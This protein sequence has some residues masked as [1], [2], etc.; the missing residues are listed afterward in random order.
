VGFILE[1]AGIGV[2]DMDYTNGKLQWSAALEAQYGLK[3]GT[4]EGTFRSFLDRV[5]PDDREATLATIEKTL[6]IGG[7]F[8]LTHRAVW[9]DGTV[10]WLSGPGCIH[11]GDD[12]K[13]VRA[14]GISQDVT[15]KRALEAQY[16]Q[17]QKME[18]VG[19]LAGSVAHDFNNLLTVMLGF[20][21]LLLDDLES[22]DQRGLIE[23]I[24]AA[25]KKASALTKQLLEFSR[26]GA[27]AEPSV[28]DLNA[29]LLELQPM[30]TRLLGKDVKLV[31]RPSTE[32]ALLTVN[33][34]HIEQIVMNLASNA[35]DAMP[36]GGTFTIA[37]TEVRVGEADSTAS[38][39]AGEYLCLA[40]RDT[41]TG[42]DPELI[43][44]IFD[45]HF[46]TKDPGKGT[47]L[48]LSATRGIV[49]Q[50]GGD[51]RVVSAMGEGTT[52]VIRLPRIEPPEALVGTPQAA[53]AS[54]G[55]VPIVLVVDDGKAMRMLVAEMLRLNGYEALV[56][57][58]AE[59][60]MAVC[61]KTPHIDVLVTDVVM[62]GITG[63]E[64]AQR[65]VALRPRLR[66]VF[67]SGYKEAPAV[68][69]GVW[70]AGFLQKPF[71][72]PDLLRKIEEQLNCRPERHQEN[73]R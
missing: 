24:Q 30:L 20:S 71:G 15:E 65:M 11:L 46:T 25:G 42:V 59:E 72:A 22:E 50:S 56:A 61:D 45:A 21:D 6:A 32:P 31:L 2:W 29:L 55:P 5:H 34:G 17:A 69:K 3:P 54:K 58:S 60:A 39:R 37:L 28:T 63:P 4:F 57:G 62:P 35:R 18:A 53:V 19:Q 8:T 70:G 48:G 51:I 36:L 27:S 14:T 10:R 13:P 7:E 9:P 73:G 66:V 23:E 67:M 64:L 52:F 16:L 43:E 49:S 12:G 44:R 1:S 33:R 41:G 47:G 26:Q 40:F 38:L 68:K